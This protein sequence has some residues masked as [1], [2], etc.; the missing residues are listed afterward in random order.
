MISRLLALNF[1]PPKEIAKQLIEM[2]RNFYPTREVPAPYYLAINQPLL[3]IHG[4]ALD[5][6]AVIAETKPL[7]YID[8]PARDEVVAE[9]LRI[10]HQ[11]NFHIVK[12]IFHNGDKSYLISKNM[13]SIQTLIEARNKYFLSKI[14]REEWHTITGCCLGYPAEAIQDFLEK[15]K[16]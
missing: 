14:T 3:Y 16:N 9:L 12:P 11:H 2:M 4:D 6:A 15:I 13:T 1:K 7:A 5:L 8:R 10:A